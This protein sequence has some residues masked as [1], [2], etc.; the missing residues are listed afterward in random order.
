MISPA[1]I[2]SRGYLVTRSPLSM[3][4]RG[5]LRI[6]GTIY[7]LSLAFTAVGTAVTTTALRMGKSLTYS[8]IGTA[9]SSQS[10]IAGGGGA[11][12]VFRVFRRIIR[13]LRR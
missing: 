5:Y 9:S 8:A 6:S 13:L 3:A 4:S 11:A 12:A 1:S 2:A 7:D 10:F